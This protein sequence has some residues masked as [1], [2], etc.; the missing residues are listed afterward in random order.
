VAENVVPFDLGVTWQPNAP[1]AILVADDLGKTA[2]ALEPH[3]DDFDRRGVVIVWNGTRSAC[4]TEP[5]DEA[6]SGHR[7][8]GKGLSK[9]L[10]AGLVRDS[11][12]IEALE[13]QNRVHPHHDPSRFDRLAHYVILSKECIAEV[14]AE[15]V[16]V[17][18]IEGTMLDAATAA[19][20][21]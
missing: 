6:I 18:R 5:N 13:R 11:Q 8:Y 12:A 4:L 1:S 10:W 17:Q 16:E 9:V 19:I 7:L 15:A 14:V 21:L 2:L 3:P 20:R